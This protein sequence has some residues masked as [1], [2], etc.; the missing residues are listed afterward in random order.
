MVNDEKITSIRRYID[1]SL[2]KR[3]EELIG[4]DQKNFAFRW[5]LF[6]RGDKPR[7]ERKVIQLRIDLWT[8]VISGVGAV[9]AFLL[10]A[11]QNPPK[12]YLLY[13]DIV[14]ALAD[15]VILS[16]LAIQF[17]EYSQRATKDDPQTSKKA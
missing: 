7:L 4:S 15:L 9:G 14:A 10:R 1:K 5:E 3:I 8:F 13:F 12:G 2:S 17:I 16:M 11:L 6:H